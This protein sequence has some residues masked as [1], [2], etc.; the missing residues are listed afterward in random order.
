VTCLDV[1]EGRALFSVQQGNALALLQALPDGCID[2]TITDPPYSS[3]GQFRGDRMASTTEKYVMRDTMFVRPDFA[4]DNRDQR[5]Y[6]YW[7]A[8]WMAECLRVTKPGG[9]FMCFTDWRQ[10]GST[11]DALQAGGFVYRGIVPWDKTEGVRPQMGRFSSQFEYVIWGTAG[12]RETHEDV[13][14]LPGGITCFPKPSE[15]HHQT[16]KPVAV[17]QKLVRIAP[18]GGVIL[19]LF[20][21]GGSTAVGA[22]LEG[23]RV[24]VFEQVEA[25]VETIKA[26]CVATVNSTTPK[27]AAAGQGALFGSNT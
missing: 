13:G 11:I 5:A 4:G 27:A 22:L 26:R 3:G 12:A 6:A 25:Y 21:G 18:P 7:C 9:V 16:G 24:I 19:D 8:I 10:I 2:A 23:R 1:L 17:L 14:C 20:G 15:K